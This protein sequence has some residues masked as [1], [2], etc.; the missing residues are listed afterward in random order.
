MTRLAYWIGIRRW[1]S[2]MKTIAAI[3]ARATKGIMTLKTWS[4]FVHQACTPCGSRLTIDAKI[5]SEIPLPIP[6]WVMSSPIHISRTVPAVSEHDEEDVGTS[7]CGMIGA[8]GG[9][10]EALEEEDVADR[11]ARRRGRR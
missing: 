3:T 5:I 8:P 6:R 7:K 11:L 2:W 4:G 9:R 1:P 10:R